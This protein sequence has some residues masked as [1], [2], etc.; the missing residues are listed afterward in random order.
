MTSL[1]PFG[2]I[3]KE[4]GWMGELGVHSGALMAD[5]H[6]KDMEFTETVQKAVAAV[7]PTI[8]E[9]DRK[10]RRDLTKEDMTIFT[11]GGSNEDLDNAFSI[12][13]Q[14]KGIFEIGIHVSD[15]S[16]YIRVNTPL[17]REARERSCSV[18]LV[19]KKIAILPLFFTEAHCSLG[20]VDKER[21]AFS[22]LCRFTENGVLLHAWIGKTIVKSKGHVH[23]P[24]SFTDDQQHETEA[25][26][27]LKADAKILLKIC[28]KLQHN[29]LNK[30]NGTSLAKS[31]VKFKLAESGYPEEI[32]RFD[33]TD[34][35]VLLEELL[36]VANIEVGQKISSRFPDQGLLYR[37]DVPKMSKLVSNKG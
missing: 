20:V 37:Q 25:E 15:V 30:L 11:M 16:S 32:N 14:E 19:D 12:T 28:Q 17:D 3:E 22:V 27:S 35:D 13:S 2:L 1:H 6:I 10:G 29:R 33:Q 18:Q 31:H 34:K 8:S 5:H 9:E 4:I 7:P 36:I 24:F 21:Q 26:D 23:L